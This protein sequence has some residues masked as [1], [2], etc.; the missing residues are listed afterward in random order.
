MAVLGRGGAN[1]GERGETNLC[2]VLTGK[3]A[4][5]K[6][7]S[8]HVVIVDLKN[9]QYAIGDCHLDTRSASVRD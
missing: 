5:Q 7:I 4:L 3:W 1:R 8:Y 2:V 9:A 6:D